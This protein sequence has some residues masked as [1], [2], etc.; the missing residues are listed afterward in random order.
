MNPT[1][2]LVLVSILCLFVNPYAVVV[3]SAFGHVNL[4][5]LL[6]T[7]AGNVVINFVLHRLFARHNVYDFLSMLKWVSIPY[8]VTLLIPLSQVMYIVSNM[9]ISKMLYGSPRPEEIHLLYTATTY[10]A[11]AYAAYILAATALHYALRRVLKSEK[12]TTQRH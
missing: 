8:T 7:V 1:G 10:I 3:S 5:S 11:I 6:F 9:M 12:R 4:W 2:L